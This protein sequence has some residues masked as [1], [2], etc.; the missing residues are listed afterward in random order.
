MTKTE[1]TLMCAVLRNREEQASGAPFL[2]IRSKGKRR[3]YVTV[4][5]DT[6]EALVTNK[7]S[8]HLYAGQLRDAVFHALVTSIGL[9]PEELDKA[10]T[11]PEEIAAVELTA[12]LA[13][14]QARGK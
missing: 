8:Q 4:D 7:E 3:V 5:H 14:E 12:E 1:S 13:A 2:E 11:T 6:G 10:M 9:D